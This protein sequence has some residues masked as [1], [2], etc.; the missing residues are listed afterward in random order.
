MTDVIFLQRAID[1]AIRYSADG[2]HG[3]FGAVIV[4]DGDIIAEGWN[5]VVA[6]NDPTA[7]AEIM[8]IRTACRQLETHHLNGCTIYASCE[9]CPMCLSAIYWA[10]IST[11]VYAASHRDAAKAGFDDFFLYNE[12]KSSWMER[13]IKS[14]RGLEQEGQAVFKK[15][16]QNPERINY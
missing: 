7:H 2:Q 4:K 10:R 13:K 6:F 14:H 3:P 11:V 16:L 1:L 8:A 5:Q 15:W 12:I 9:P